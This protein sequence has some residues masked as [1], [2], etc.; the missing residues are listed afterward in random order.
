M[1]ETWEKLADLH[2]LTQ[3]LESSGALLKKPPARIICS[4]GAE[5]GRR[6]R[7]KLFDLKVQHLAS[8]LRRGLFFTALWKTRNFRSILVLCWQ[9]K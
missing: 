8:A 6:R 2:Q 4:A 3:K 1:A 7:S 9:A 5:S